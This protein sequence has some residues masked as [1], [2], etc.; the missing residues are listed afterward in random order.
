MQVYQIYREAGNMGKILPE[1]LSTWTTNKV[2]REMVT[3]INKTE[4]EDVSMSDN[5]KELILHLSNG[6]TVNVGHV[7]VAV[8]VEPNTQL[9]KTSDLEVDPELGG[10]LVNAEMEARSNLYAVRIKNHIT[11]VVP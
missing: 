7:I 2:R 4:V 11:L 6:D 5:K 3:I 10:Y 1:Y 9:A 8:G